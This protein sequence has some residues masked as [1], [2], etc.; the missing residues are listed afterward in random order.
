MAR[1]DDFLAE[2]TIQLT[3][4]VTRHPTLYSYSVSQVPG[5]ITRIREALPAN[6]YMTNGRAFRATCR[7]L[8]I[9]PTYKAVRDFLQY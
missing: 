8:G 5:V 2:Y 3:R 4:A 7:N 9:K 6:K 1:I